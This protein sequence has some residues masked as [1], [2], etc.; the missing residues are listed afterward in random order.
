MSTNKRDPYEVLGVSRN[1]TKDEIKRAF[2]KKAI[3]YHPDKNPDRRKWAEEKFKELAEAYEVLN[4]DQKRQ[5]YDRFGWDG[6]QKSGFSGFGNINFEDLFSNFG[7]IF[8]GGLGD[9]FG[10]FFGFGRRRRPRQRRGSDVR[11]DLEISLEDAFKGKKVEIRVPKHI[12]CKACGGS[13]AQSPS[14]ISTCPACGGSGQR[15]Q[16]RATPFGQMINVTTCSKCQGTGQVITKKCKDCKGTGRIKKV[17]TLSI[18]IPAGVESG[19][20][21]RIQGEGEA[22]PQGAPPGDLY[23]VIHVKPHPIFERHNSHLICEKKIT[24]SQAV[25]GGKIEVPTLDGATRL[26]IPAGTKSGTVF[27]LKGKGMPKV[28][29]YGRGDILCKVEIEVPD[30]ITNAQKE[31]LNR[32]KELGL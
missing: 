31:V 27:R 4:D 23:V 14:D 21:L 8:G 2:R 28:H 10:D 13:G 7:D 16:V 3:Q 25:L 18:D 32:L 9:L 30:K 15:Q 22:G 6:V 24:F 26:T 20:R 12:S 29:R 11:L 17:R 5:M 1:A 19:N